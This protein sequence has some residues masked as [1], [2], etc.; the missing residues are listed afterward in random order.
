MEQKLWHAARAFSNERASVLWAES[1]GNGWGTFKWPFCLKTDFHFLF[2][3]TFSSGIAPRCVYCELCVRARDAVEGY[4]TRW[5]ILPWCIICMEIFQ[6]T[7]KYVQDTRASWE[8]RYVYLTCWEANGGKIHKKS[9]KVFGLFYFCF[10][11]EDF[12]LALQVNEEQ[13]QKV[14]L[15]CCRYT[16]VCPL[17]VKKK[18]KEK[19]EILNSFVVIFKQKDYFQIHYS[20]LTLLLSSYLEK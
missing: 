11:H 13:Y 16:F 3:F 15:S 9:T 18:K 1:K 10:Q 19:R 8:N 14:S 7:T 12:L 6:F 20:Y 17:F 4:Q 2:K 5:E